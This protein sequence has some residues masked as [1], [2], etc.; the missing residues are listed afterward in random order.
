MK[1]R[2]GA[3]SGRRQK[4][5]LSAAPQ[6]S[7]FYEQNPSVV[8]APKIDVLYIIITQIFFS[9]FRIFSLHLRQLL[10]RHVHCPNFCG[11][12]GFC[13][14][15]HKERA[16]RQELYKKGFAQTEFRAMNP[17][18]RTSFATSTISFLQNDRNFKKGKKERW[19]ELPVGIRKY[20]GKRKMSR[21]HHQLRQIPDALIM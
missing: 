12:T 4:I 15:L 8:F 19:F 17:P 3:L 10:G 11:T 20:R 14:A 21:H 13:R 5:G 7:S 9:F 6:N 16:I 2:Y 1:N 18:M